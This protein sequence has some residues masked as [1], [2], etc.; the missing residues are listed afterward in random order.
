MDKIKSLPP[1]LAEDFNNKWDTFCIAA[2][3]ANVMPP[4]DPD[5][6]FPMEDYA[7]ERETPNYAHILFSFDPLFHP[8]GQQLARH[9]LEGLGD[10]RKK[11]WGITQMVASSLKQ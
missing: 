11:P 4:D 10:F 6:P 9:I 8:K 2:E 5:V 1:P 7:A 3:N